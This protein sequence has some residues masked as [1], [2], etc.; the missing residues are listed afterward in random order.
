MGDGMIIEGAAAW[1]KWI[2]QVY[3]Q[4]Y[5]SK[6]YYTVVKFYELFKFIYNHSTEKNCFRVGMI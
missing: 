4:S 6:Y 5:K 2:V 1:V 3:L